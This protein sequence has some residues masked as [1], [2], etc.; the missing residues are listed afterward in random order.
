MARDKSVVY[1]SKNKSQLARIF[2]KTFQNSQ[3][4]DNP[5]PFPTTQDL[6][7][8][9]KVYP[10]GTKVD[11]E[12]N[13][14]LNYRNLI[15]GSSKRLSCKSVSQKTNFGNTQG[16]AEKLKLMTNHNNA[17]L[18]CLASFKTPKPDYRGVTFNPISETQKGLSVAINQAEVSPSKLFKPPNMEFKFDDVQ[19]FVPGRTYAFNSG[20]AVTLPDAF[21]HVT[22]APDLNDGKCRKVLME[23]DKKPQLLDGVNKKLNLVVVPVV[24]LYTLDGKQVEPSNVLV[25]LCPLDHKDTGP[26][27]ASF[28]VNSEIECNLLKIEFL[29][30]VG[31]AI[32]VEANLINA[33]AGDT[34]I[35]KNT[36]GNLVMNPNLHLN[37]ES[38]KPIKTKS[39]LKLDIESQVKKGL[40]V[41]FDKNAL[42]FATRK[43]EFDRAEMI[44]SAGFFNPSAPQ[45]FI[46]PLVLSTVQN[47]FD[48]NTH[49]ITVIERRCHLVSVD[50][51]DKLGS[52][53]ELIAI[54]GYCYKVTNFSLV[55]KRAKAMPQLLANLKKMIEIVNKDGHASSDS[56]K[57]KRLL[58]LDNLGVNFVLDE[59][60]MKR[61]SL[62]NDRQLFESEINRTRKPNSTELVLSFDVLMS[63]ETCEV[64]EATK[65]LKNQVKEKQRIEM[66]KQVLA[67][68]EKEL[69]I[70]NLNDDQPEARRKLDEK[71]EV[72]DDQ[73]KT[74]RKQDDDDDDA[75]SKKIKLDDEKTT[76]N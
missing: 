42:L 45:T 21:P 66:E 65:Q 69:E 54:N 7:A 56:E 33:D 26:M 12:E 63:A 30:F 35:R 72:D 44:S 70:Q 57:W 76:L 64:T 68:K 51:E 16:A 49:S 2:P 32:D 29:G 40:K 47:K 23:G 39:A 1:D 20:Y 17:V 22:I 9:L 41:R 38:A 74:K 59:F 18:S 24:R 34:L 5:P 10:E 58:I 3:V 6:E 75:Q 11:T 14:G 55:K 13:V 60:N 71:I 8:G 36:N 48:S 73:P 50:F 46:K 37:F 31:K 67:E 62:M 15:M 28:C 27:F 61:L 19:Q 4:V 25:K 43:R 53:H 52:F